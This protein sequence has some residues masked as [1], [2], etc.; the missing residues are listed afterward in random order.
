MGWSD[1][2]AVFGFPTSFGSTYPAS[3]LPAETCPS[4]IAVSQEQQLKEEWVLDDME[5]RNRLHPQKVRRRKA[6]VE[7]PLGTMKR[8]MNQ[9]YFLT[10]GLEMVKAEMSLTVT[11][12]NLKRVLN[13]PGVKRM[14]QALAPGPTTGAG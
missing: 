4:P 5:R 8:S 11:A 7:H 1:S 3:P 10:R 9:G 13:I 14:V 2:H 12:Y 6:I